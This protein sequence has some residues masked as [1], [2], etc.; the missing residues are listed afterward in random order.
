[1]QSYVLISEDA[2]FSL[3]DQ[4]SQRCGWQKK[5]FKA[6]NKT[7]KGKQQIQFKKIVDGWY[8]ILEGRRIHWLAV[9][10]STSACLKEGVQLK[11]CCCP[12]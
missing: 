1:M 4:E 9:Y 11:L 10:R 3:V 12:N 5:L 8:I 7:K 2:L 6:I